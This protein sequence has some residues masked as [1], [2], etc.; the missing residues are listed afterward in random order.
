MPTRNWPHP[1]LD[2]QSDDYPNCAFQARFLARQTKLDYML[3][4]EFDLGCESLEE[5]IVAGDAQYL[6]HINCARTAYRAA[7][8]VSTP[9]LEITIPE[10]ELRD[11][12]VVSPYIVS[13]A[14]FKLKSVELAPMFQELT[15]TVRPGAVLAVAPSVEYIAEKVFDELKN[16]SAI[17]QVVKQYSEAKNAVEYDLAGN[18]IVIALPHKSYDDYRIFPTRHYTVGF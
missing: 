12:F 1:V 15:F 3:H 4:A 2:S 10:H 18:K 8:P 11:A 16:I 13:K 6:V 14:V 7:F 5:S 9:S 17:F